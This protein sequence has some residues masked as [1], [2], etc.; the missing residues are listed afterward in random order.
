[1]A[2]MK[3]YQKCVKERFASFV[4]TLSKLW[5]MIPVCLGL[6]K[7]GRAELA[8]LRSAVR[9]EIKRGRNALGGEPVQL[10]YQLAALHK[11]CATPEEFAP[12]AWAALTLARLSRCP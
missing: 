4:L 9:A 11:R 12:R 10:V 2:V 6:S 5:F 7:A 1:M 8:R 3:E